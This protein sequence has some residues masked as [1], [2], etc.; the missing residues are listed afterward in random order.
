MEY[1][2][3]FTHGRA[4]GLYGSRSGFYLRIFMEA[5][6]D[7]AQCLKDET[8]IFIGGRPC[9]GASAM[10]TRAR[11]VGDSADGYDRAFSV[12]RDRRRLFRFGFC[13]AFAGAGGFPGR[14]LDHHKPAALPSSTANRTVIWAATSF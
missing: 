8:C 6:K 14:E 11:G 5:R 1:C 10:A 13:C 7:D 9:S 2:R 4:N 12:R 3:R